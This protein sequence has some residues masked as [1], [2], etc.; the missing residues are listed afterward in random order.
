MHEVR[1][2]WLEHHVLV[3]PEQAMSNDDLVRFAEYLGPIGDDPY[4][5]PIDGHDR[6]AAVQR[7]ADETGI[8]FADSWHGDW[9]FQVRPPSGT[10]LLSLTIPPVGGDT[11]FT[12]QHMALDEMPAAMREKLEGKTGLHSARW[13]YANDGK[14]AEKSFDGSMAIRTSDTANAVHGHPLIRSHPETGRLGLFGGSYVFAIEGMPEDEGETLRQ[15]IAQWQACPEFQYR[16]KWQA[17]MLVLW[18]NR[19][20]LHKANGGYEGHDR[21]LHRLTVADDEGYYLQ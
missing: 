19:A 14:Y 3:F 12:N 2:A 11:Q 13:A 10:C 16:H 5:K 17:N 18:D 7:R 1:A 21:L 9:S 4:F 6:I 8:L 20:V 15:E